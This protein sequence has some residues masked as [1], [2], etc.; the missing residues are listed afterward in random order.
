MNFATVREPTWRYVV[1]GLARLFEERRGTKRVV[2]QR[3]VGTNAVRMHGKFG[4]LAE[5][6]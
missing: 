1:L 6:P 5:D 2:V 4:S 3:L